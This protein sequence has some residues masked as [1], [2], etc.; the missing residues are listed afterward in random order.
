MSLLLTSKPTF[1][2]KESWLNSLYNPA[3]KLKYSKYK[4]EATLTSWIRQQEK[5]SLPFTERRGYFSFLLA[6]TH[7]LFGVM[8]SC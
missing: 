3:K 5:Q 1:H 6:T 8:S 2:L 7:Q 4:I